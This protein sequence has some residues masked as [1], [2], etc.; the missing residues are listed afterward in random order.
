VEI[1]RKE[2]QPLLAFRDTDGQAL[3]VSLTGADVAVA[4]AVEPI[5]A[6]GISINSTSS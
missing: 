6:W 1:G 2:T 3:I 5:P 4:A